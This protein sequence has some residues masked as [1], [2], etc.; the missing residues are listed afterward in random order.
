MSKRRR[1]Y[2]R[3]DTG[4]RQEAELQSEE[5]FPYRTINIKDEKSHRNVSSARGMLQKSHI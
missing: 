2:S 5:D 3:K 1:L 4:R